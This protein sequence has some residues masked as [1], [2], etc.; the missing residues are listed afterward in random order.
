ME[1]LGI[2]RGYL[3]EA[4]PGVLEGGPRARRVSLNTGFEQCEEWEGVKLGEISQKCSEQ[5]GR[6]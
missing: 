2:R 4:A 1:A 6:K 5:K 3:E